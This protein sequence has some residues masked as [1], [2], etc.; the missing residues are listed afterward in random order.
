MEAL[1]VVTR[2]DRFGDLGFDL[3]SDHVGEEHVGAGPSTRLPERKRRRQHGSRRMR[4]EAIHA[5][6]Q[7]GE[8]CVVVVIPMNRQTIE[9]RGKSGWNAQRRSQGC[10]I[11]GCAPIRAHLVARNPR[12]LRPRSCDG[13]T[14]SV[15]HG[16]LRSREHRGWHVG[17][18]RPGDEYSGVLGGISH[19]AVLHSLSS[20]AHRLLGHADSLR[21]AVD[22]V[23]PG[24]FP[25]RSPQRLT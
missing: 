19:R 13:E 10:S 14:E 24:C 8:L 6:G 21:A 22:M 20:R 12:S 1:V 4:Q 15:E 3:D 17:K 7:G 11:N 25:G 5:I 9:E 23:R 16:M 18:T 2:V